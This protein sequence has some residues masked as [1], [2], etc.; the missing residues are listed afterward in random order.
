VAFDAMQ[1]GFQLRDG[2]CVHERRYWK[3]VINKFGSP[4]VCIGWKS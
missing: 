2:G 4:S 3:R 1:A